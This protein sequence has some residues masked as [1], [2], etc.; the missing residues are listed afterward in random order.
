MSLFGRIV[1]REEPTEHERSL[2][3]CGEPRSHVYSIKE[4]QYALEDL[5]VSAKRMTDRSGGAFPNARLMD[6]ARTLFEKGLKMVEEAATVFKQADEA[7][8]GKK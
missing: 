3:E 8:I 4:V 6:K 2:T 1:E 7:N 5:A